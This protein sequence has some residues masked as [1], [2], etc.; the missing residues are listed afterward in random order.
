[1]EAFEGERVR[2]ATAGRKLE[3]MAKLA[4]MMEEEGVS[5]DHMKQMVKLLTNFYDFCD[6]FHFKK[7]SSPF[8]SL[9]SSLLSLSGLASRTYSLPS[10]CAPYLN[11]TWSKRAVCV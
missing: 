3:E 11:M 2:L 10:E 5:G 6:F 7:I 8:S 1:M 9:L 4:I